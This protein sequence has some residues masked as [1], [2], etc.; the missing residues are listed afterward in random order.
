[1]RFQ[2][3]GIRVDPCEQI[4]DFVVYFELNK[5]VPVIDILE[6]KGGEAAIAAI[7]QGL[8]AGS[9][10]LFAIIIITLI[11]LSAT[12]DSAS[13]TLASAASKRLS[14]DE[15][16]ARW[17]KFFWAF[18]IELVA[19]SMMFGGGLHA[20]QSVVVITSVPL[21]FIMALSAISLVKWLQ[22]DEIRNGS[23][24][25]VDNNEAKQLTS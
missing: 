25:R 10:A 5:L 20:L 6:K 16:P 17:Q 14:L 2:L 7:Y 22:E 18:I 12:L 11:F 9:I 21:I 19:F 23:L 13:Y 3:L 15:E 1:M 8:P 24:D 4:D